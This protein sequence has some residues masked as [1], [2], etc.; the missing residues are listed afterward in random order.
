MNLIGCVFQ[1]CNQ[2]TRNSAVRQILLLKMIRPEGLCLAKVMVAPKTTGSRRMAKYRGILLNPACC[3]W[4]LHIWCN[5]RQQNPCSTLEQ[6]KGQNV[7]LNFGPSCYGW[8][9]VKIFTC[10]LIEQHKIGWL[11]MDVCYLS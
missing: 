1:K 5:I 8:L 7:N 10:P 11:C 9:E 3:I 4:S 6:V 2:H